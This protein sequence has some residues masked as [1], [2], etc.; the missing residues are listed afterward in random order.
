MGRACGRLWFAQGWSKPGHCGA[1]NVAQVSPSHARARGAARQNK[2]VDSP[3]LLSVCFHTL[4]PESNLMAQ[5]FF[6]GRF[7][8]PSTSPRWMRGCANG[9]A[10]KRTG[11]TIRS[12][13]KK[14]SEGW[15]RLD[16][17]LR[18][19]GEAVARLAITLAGKT[20]NVGYGYERERNLEEAWALLRHACLV[21]EKTGRKQTAEDYGRFGITPP[22]EVWEQIKPTPPEPPEPKRWPFSDLYNKEQEVIPIKGPNGNGEMDEFDWKQLVPWEQGEDE[23]EKPKRTPY[24]HALAVVTE[25]ITKRVE[26]V[27][28]ESLVD[29]LCSSVMD[30]PW[31]FFTTTQDKN[32]K[33]NLS[34]WSEELEMFEQAVKEVPRPNNARVQNTF[35]WSTMLARGSKGAERELKILERRDAKVAGPPTS[36]DATA[37]Q[38]YTELVAWGGE[39]IEHWKSKLI[40]FEFDIFW[41]EGQERGFVW[42]DVIALVRQSKTHK[43]GIK[44]KSLRGVKSSEKSNAL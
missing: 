43:N 38:L 35:N 7:L 4:S 42:E 1:S 39:V 5:R 36:D 11:R 18:A 9:V 16:P 22:K 26:S 23:S 3:L 8:H 12:M 24:K 2:G 13:A 27:A 34:V 31:R 14:K 30:D 29:V 32:G 40:A 41:R 19:T 33:W 10:I 6:V 15:E 37:E 21:V 25:R 28:G 44:W 20:R 17:E